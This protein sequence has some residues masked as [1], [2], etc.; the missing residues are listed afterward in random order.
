MT[1]TSTPATP[2]QDD[3][4]T[5]LRSAA[6]A[7]LIAAVGIVITP[8]TVFGTGLVVPDFN[9][10][11][12]AQD[13]AWTRNFLAL[14]LVYGAQGILIAGAIALL[15]LHSRRVLAPSISRDLG[16]VAGL[17]TALG[18][19]ILGGSSAAQY[20]TALGG[21]ELLKGVPD[22]A[23][24]SLVTL[25]SLFTTQGIMGAAGVGLAVWGIILATTGRRQ[26]VVGCVFPVFAWIFGVLS[27]LVYVSGAGAAAS[28]IGL[29]TL[30]ATALAL[31]RA[32]RRTDSTL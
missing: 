7:A 6:R 24:R 2:I 10:Q 5:H 20:S 18:W 9:N 26:D 4:T 30:V 3:K 17:T 22:V 32:A 15:V 8:I 13:P 12:L 31:F 23:T 27:A 28:L 1:S 16:T 11:T 19:L 25:A 14:A 21:G 29:G